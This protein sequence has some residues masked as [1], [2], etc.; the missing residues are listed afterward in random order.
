MLYVSN[1]V[2]WLMEYLNGGKLRKKCMK[3]KVKKYQNEVIQPT[4]K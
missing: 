4:V 1:K 2:R 3:L